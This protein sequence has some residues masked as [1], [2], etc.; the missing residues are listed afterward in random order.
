MSF[1]RIAAYGGIGFVILLVVNIVLLGN[2]PA[3]TDSIEKISDY[4]GD[5]T[6][7][8][9][10]AFLVGIALLPFFAVFLAGV[11]TEMRATDRE[12]GEGWAIVTLAGGILIGASAGVGDALLGALFYRGGSGLDPAVIRAVWDAQAI[13]YTATGL[14]ITALAGG[15]AVVS[16]HRGRGPA[17]YGWLSALV[18]ALGLLTLVGI[19]STSTGL[20]TVAFLALPGL[21]VWVIVT[22]VLML[23]SPRAAA[24]ATA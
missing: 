22:S 10:I 7:L 12:H 2:Q 6:E 23:R 14:G 21:L 20:N 3:A 24:P 16:L 13:A 17:W 1:R 11:V 18:A 5:N 9:K 4:L 8:H 15:A 19:M